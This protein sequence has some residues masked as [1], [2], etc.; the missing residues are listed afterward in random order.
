MSTREE[1]AI[2]LYKTGGYGYNCSQSVIG[3][4]CEDNG[5]ELDTALKLA[6][7]FGGGAT[8]YK[9]M[10]GALTGAIMV[11]GL[12][13]GNYIK[14]DLEAKKFCYAK[15]QEFIEKFKAKSGSI[16]CSE[17][18]GVKKGVEIEPK[19]FPALRP[20]FSSVCPEVIKT[21]VKLLEGMD[22]GRR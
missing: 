20:A 19:D 8:K 11:I 1:K 18:L 2:E 12:K 7:G 15:T 13:C 6:S 17:V 22:F 5:L 14:G 4:F 3:A 21:A 9:G 16:I 10:C